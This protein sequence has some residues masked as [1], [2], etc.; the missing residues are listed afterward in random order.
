MILA[1]NRKSE[2]EGYY[3]HHSSNSTGFHSTD[4]FTTNLIQDSV[5]ETHPPT[6]T[7]E[8]EKEREL[9]Q[10]RTERGVG[11]QM[12]KG[13]TGEFI[14]GFGT[15]R[16]ERNGTERNGP[17]WMIIEQ[18]QFFIYVETKQRINLIGGNEKL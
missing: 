7:G 9:W 4:N 13:G 14:E 15:S 3:H 1:T 18:V 11:L 12:A 10:K 6:R 8:R 17:D 5:S 2:G 16:T